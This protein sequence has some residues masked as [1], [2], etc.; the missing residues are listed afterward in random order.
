MKQKDAIKIET[1]NSNIKEEAVKLE[2]TAP[3]FASS[4]NTKKR[5]FLNNNDSNKNKKIIITEAS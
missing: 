5:F 1:A 3:A 2:Y 4:P